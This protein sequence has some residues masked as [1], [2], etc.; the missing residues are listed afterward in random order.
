M[1]RHMAH[2]KTKRGWKY[3][4]TMSEIR[5]TA[6][7]TAPRRSPKFAT[8]PS[9]HDEMWRAATSENIPEIADDL[10]TQLNRCYMRQANPPEHFKTLP[11]DPMDRHPI[12]APNWTRCIGSLRRQ[13]RAS[14]KSLTSYEGFLRAGNKEGADCWIVVRWNAADQRIWTWRLSRTRPRL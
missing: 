5:S 12:R 6:K 1:I 7:P 11:S 9:L 14:P 4:T 10:R 13:N 2:A 3:N 8:A